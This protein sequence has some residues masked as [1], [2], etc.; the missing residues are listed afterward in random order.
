MPKGLKTCPQCQNS[1][2]PR[3]I[4]C[5]C[6]HEFTTVVKKPKAACRATEV[7]TPTATSETAPEIVCVSDEGA[8]TTFIK[9]LKGAASV[10]KGTGGCYSA[11]LHHKYGV[12][13][14]EV[15]FPLQLKG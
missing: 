13:Q 4:T 9:R 8:L 14:V 11:F 6:G 12:L 5:R 2:G 3:T 1:V 10:S 15:Y 7:E